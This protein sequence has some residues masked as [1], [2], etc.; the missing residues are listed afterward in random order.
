M[1][2]GL[3]WELFLELYYV[4]SSICVVYKM[5]DALPM[6]APF[7][8]RTPIPRICSLIWYLTLAVSIGILFWLIYDWSKKRN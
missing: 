3:Q 5:L 7:C 2:F 4:L 6:F 1:F 8:F